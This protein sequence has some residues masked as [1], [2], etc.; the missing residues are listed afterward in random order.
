MMNKP[1]AFALGCLLALAA[2]FATK[3][4]TTWYV[5]KSGKDTNSG[6][7]ESAAFLTIQ[8]A[9]DQAAEGDVV[10]VGP[11]T[12]APFATG[13]KVMRIESTDGPD[14]TVVVG[15]TASGVKGVNAGGSGANTVVVGFTV[16]N[17]WQ[18]LSGG[19]YS[20]CI[21]T[22]CQG[23]EQGA[24][25]VSAVLDS[26][27][28]Y[29]NS[30]YSMG[31]GAAYSTLVNCTVYGNRTNLGAGGVY[32]CAT[33]NCIIIGNM[34]Q[35]YPNALDSSTV[36]GYTS[37]DAKFVNASEG[38]FRL[39]STSPCV[40]T[41][42]SSGVIGKIDLDGNVRIAG[43]AVDIGCYEYGSSAPVELTGM[44]ATPRYPWNGKVDLKFTIDGTS[45]VKYDTSF[46]AQDVAG[47]TNLTMKTLYKSDGT[48]ANVA[49]EQ[50]LPGTYNWVWDATADLGVGTV[51]DRVTIT[52]DVK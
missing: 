23:A 33:T 31:G 5:T 12:Y 47:G 11:G 22:G 51:L 32:A 34:A 48:A 14:A 16:K 20:R 15:T 13:G 35:V 21:V 9:V 30:A 2:P 4:A 19:R 3:A 6:K 17:C 36:N 10:K 8:K 24:G 52:V 43:S 18:G 29:N 45:G 38:N 40:N 39:A 28:L 7:S 44:T 46:S 49:K 42:L 1:S 50:L 41:G 25:A 26:C 27:L 37:G